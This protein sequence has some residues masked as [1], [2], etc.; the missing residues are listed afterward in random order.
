MEN[1]KSQKFFEALSDI[2]A[3][4]LNAI[5]ALLD[6]RKIESIN[7]YAYWSEKDLDRNLFFTCDDDGYGRALYIEKLYYKNDGTHKSLLL[8]M[9]DVNDYR[10][11]DWDE[12]DLFESSQMYYLLSMLEDIVECADE[13]DEGRILKAEEEFGDWEDVE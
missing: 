6:E 2:R 13:D 7:L 5:Y 12:T 11:C 9:Y 8:I 10:F 4:I 3:E 1:P